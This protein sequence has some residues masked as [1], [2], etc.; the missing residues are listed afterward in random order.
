MWI[1]ELKNGDSWMGIWKAKIHCPN[2]WAIFDGSICPVCNKELKFEDKIF[3]DDKDNEHRISPC[4]AGA[5]NWSNYVILNLMQ[6]EWE[7]PLLPDEN[8]KVHNKKI[9]QHLSIVILFW[10]LFE[11]LTDQLFKDG[12]KHLPTN[13]LNDLLKRYSSVGS[14]LDRLYKIAFSTS[15][16]DDLNKVGFGHIYDHLCLVQNKRN[17]FIHGN[18][19]EIDDRL[20]MDT[21]TYLQDTQQAWILLYNLRCTKRFDVFD[22]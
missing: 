15:F 19:E 5:I 9:S 7:R 6:Q 2:C 4:F 22:K 3:F 13:I 21:I 14:R 20:I 17:S 18:P 10:S 8:L 16:K 1:D 12:L 11:N